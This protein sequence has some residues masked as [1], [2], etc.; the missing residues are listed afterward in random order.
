MSG[1]FCATAHEDVIPRVMEGLANFEDWGFDSAG[2]GVLTDHKIQRRRAKG[3][4]SSL[5]A[6]LLS[7]P[8]VSRTAIGHMRQGTHGEPARYNAQPHASSRVAVVH[9]GIIENH[10]ELRAELEHEG[11]QFRSDTDSEVIVWLLD[12]E[13]AK[14]THPLRALRSVLPRL[15]GSNALGLI[16]TNHDDR[17]Y[18]ARA[19]RPLFVGRG[20]GASWLASDEPVL[21]NVAQSTAPLENGQFAELGPGHV[22]V[23]DSDLHEVAASWTR[24]ESLASLRQSGEREIRQHVTHIEIA[25][26]PETLRHTLGELERDMKAGELEGWCGPLWYADR[27]LAVGCGTSYHAAHAARAWLEQIAGIPVELELGSELGTREPL[28]SEGTMALLVSQ[29]GQNPDMLDALSYFKAK[30]VPTVS[31]VNV[32]SSA[33]ARHS[34]AVLECRAGPYVGVATTNGF[35]AQLCALAALSIVIR[36]LKRGGAPQD[37]LLAS[38]RAVPDAMKSVLAHDNDCAAVGRRIAEAGHAIYL[39]RGTNHPVALAGALTLTTLSEAYARGLA[40]GELKHRPL[41]SMEHGTPVVVVASHDTSF[42]K[43]RSDLREVVAQGGEPILVG[44]F[45]SATMAQREGLPCISA[46]K[47]D[48]LWAPIATAVPLQ[49]IAQYAALARGG[50]LERPGDPQRTAVFD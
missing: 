9:N 44:D 29:S 38:I 35:A 6:L 13:L 28:L 19:G 22:R 27:V 18:A 2:L 17:V 33:M 7:E 40:A 48:P 46:G 36:Q 15:Q 41:S 24:V 5:A 50:S 45:E 30:D 43:A 10:A 12:R 16:C 37:D 31:L 4:L 14:R 3:P 8:L 23:F 49:L 26:Q 42:D 21:Q 11:I 20:E 47:I 34:D 39:G 32:T 1:I 25:Q